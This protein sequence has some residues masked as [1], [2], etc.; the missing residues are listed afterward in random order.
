MYK[1][2]T[3]N[4]EKS[5]LL[6]AINIYAP[7]FFQ[8]IWN[9]PKSIAT[10]LLKADKKDLKNYLAH[11]IVHSL[12]DNISSLNHR[13]DQL[14]YIITL[15]LKEEINSLTTVDNTFF[16]EKP[17]G[18]LLE[19]LNKKKEVKSF[20]KPIVLEIIKKLETKYSSTNIVLDPIA[21]KNKIESNLEISK[22]INNKENYDFNKNKL[23]NYFLNK[24][25]KENIKLV[26][27]KIKNIPINQEE[28]NK[29][30]L[31]YKDEDMK[32]FLEKLI[33]EC[34]S[35]PNKYVNE[36]LLEKLK[37]ENF[38]NY[39]Y[40]SF[41]EVI[42]IIEMFFDY[43]KNNSDLVP[44]SI[45]CICKIISI[46]MK[47]KFP[48]SIKVE[49]NIA[50]SNF[51]FHFL[52][53]P[54]LFNPCINN[55]I[56]EILLTKLTNDK[57]QLIIIIMH[58]LIIGQLFE[59][60]HYTPFNWYIIEKMPQLL[61][62]FDN[63]CQI[64]LPNF[65]DRLINE[66]L[67]HDYEYDYFRE[68]PEENILYRNVCYNPEELY[69]LIINFDKFKDEI[70]IDKKILNKLVSNI[71]I[72]EQLRNNINSIANCKGN[73][74]DKKRNSIDIKK[75]INCF[76]FT[77]LINNKKFDKIFNLKKDKN[78][79]YFNLKELKKIEKK[80]EKIQNDIIKV[81]NFFFAL[82]YNYQSLSKNEFKEEKLTDLITIL[83]ELKNNS[84]MNSSIFINNKNVP[85]NW[86]INSLIQYLPRIPKNLKENDYN[87][88]LI[89]LEN[90][91]TN[92]INELNF[93]NLSNF[94]QYLKDL[95]NEKFYYENIKNILIDIELNKITE[96]IIQNDQIVLTLDKEDKN[97]SKFFS[98]LMKDDKDFKYLFNK[99][100]KNKFYN[101]I[102]SFIKT[103]PNISKNQLHYNIDIFKI[104]E[105][106]KIPEIIENYSILIKNNLKAKNKKRIVEIHDKI[107]DY[108]MIKLY[109][110]L[111]PKEEDIIN[112]QIF[113]NCYKH[114]WIEL[115]N[116][117][118][119]KNNYIFDNY[120]PEAIN[121]FHKFENEK[122]P[123]KKLIY[124]N[125]IFNSIYNLGV[126]NGNVVEGADDE[127][128]LLNYT[129][130]KAK[131]EKI[132]TNCKYT[133]LFL[134]N[135]QFGIEGSQLTKLLGVCEKMKDMKINDL[136]GITSSEYKQNCELAV[137]NILY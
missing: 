115:S 65:I 126:F 29:K 72:I 6:G 24:I 27:D 1:L 109:D 105:E 110:K 89:E 43:L 121:Y 36:S 8:E 47:K 51:F 130:I 74:K 37:N 95:D 96:N 56:N 117:I 33:K 40:Q 118:K 99:I 102:D 11:F 111:F 41:L 79:N 98:T 133:E 3:D 103:F 73:N 61:E 108:I 16:M 131:P 112:M 129:F 59:K 114:C 44:Y 25:N 57:L 81:K 78:K 4:Q 83:K 42:D 34:S 122:T 135:K 70:N 107:Y 100:K 67:P 46:L 82:L 119:Q 54:I 136:I 97:V 63:L 71:K 45:K 127:L 77:D 26:N 21:I 124:I 90:E 15:L 13:D 19:E 132:Y 14:I 60:N 76:L 94:I 12:Y 68:N 39:Y 101:K 75:T 113:Q 123:R 35:S 134:G 20:F 93:D 66:R 88:L 2:I 10:V 18:I 17:C 58:N 22:K 86:Y 120:L 49:R 62:F 116:L 64:K 84:Y 53:F 7:E 92:S 137:K 128:P 91:I 50:L 48:D 32:E 104:I 80:E 28:L 31:E 5:K 23:D 9:N 55:F 106:K 125:K 87:E 85:L 69:S 52:F 38:M 30:L